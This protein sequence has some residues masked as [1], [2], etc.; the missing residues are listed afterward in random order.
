MAYPRRLLTAEERIVSEFRPHWKALLPPLFFTLAA[1]VVLGAMTVL[2]PEGTAKLAAM[3][4]VVL[5]WLLLAVPPF[6]RWWFTQHVLT[7][8][9]LITR[10][11]VFHRSGKEIPLEAINDVSF[12]QTLLERVLRSGDLLIE[13]AGEL[14]Q[15]RF[16]DIP[17]P[18]SFQSRIYSLREER[19]MALEGGG[20]SP[21]DPVGRLER[22]ARLHREGVLSDEE[23]EAKK[24]ELLG[25]I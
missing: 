18:E 15:S 9:R 16:T 22:L 6:V 2:V 5:V 23:F 11:G 7:N 17:D 13:S 8:E 4:L 20:P 21:D 3:G 12:S 25:Q 14:G 19:V 1:L 24:R 10:K